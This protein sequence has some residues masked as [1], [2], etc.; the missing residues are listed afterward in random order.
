M[1]Q[2]DL[3]AP[4]PRFTRHDALTKLSLY[5][6]TNLRDLSDQFGLSRI[7]CPIENK[8]WAGHSVEKL[9]GQS[10]NNDHGPDFG[11][12]ELKVLAFVQT[13]SYLEVKSQLTLTMV[14]PK[15]LEITP[16]EESYLWAK[17]Q[18]MLI[19]A[20]LYIYSEEQ[21]SPLIGYALFD[22]S[23]EIKSLLKQEYE[24]LQWLLQSQ[25]VSALKDFQGHYLNL[26]LKKATER[27][28]SFIA[29]RTL[30]NQILASFQPL[31][32]P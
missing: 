12:W 15:E 29:Q 8:G 11:E 18:K 30:L 16:F 4:P 6:G 5:W 1:S 19:V 7:G 14:Q 20:R 27:G 25:G 10:P 28:W 9:L 3:F 13:T 24:T 17:V 23:S 26:H 31:Y 21:Y 22:A 2:L 32:F